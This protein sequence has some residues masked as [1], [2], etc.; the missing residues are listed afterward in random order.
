MRYLALLLALALAVAGCGGSDDTTDTT[1]PTATTTV[2]TTTTAGATTTTA[3]TPATTQ[4]GGGSSTLTCPEI[5]AWAQQSAQAQGD[6]IFGGDVQ[7]SAD[8]FRE[9]ANNAPAEIRADFVIFADAYQQFG[10]DL[11]A[12]GIDF[13]DPDQV[14]SMDADQ[15]AE[16][17]AAAEAMATV[18]VQTA[19]DNIGTYFEEA[20]S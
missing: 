12:L 1:T 6:A 10:E 20:C 4:P 3:D 7:A 13:S 5:A 17:Q 11:A 18:E 15:A 14:S 2:A 16:L 8:Y 9:F 19:M